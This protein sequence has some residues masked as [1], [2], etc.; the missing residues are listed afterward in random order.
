MRIIA[1][2]AKGTKLDT[3]SGYNTRPTSDRV[4]EAIFSAIHFDIEGANVLDI[5][6][7]SGQLGIEAISRGANSCVFVDMDKQSL[8]VIEKNIKR[9]GFERLSKVL[10]RDAIIYLSSISESFDIVLIDPP[11]G[12]KQQDEILIKL[13]ANLNT[14]GIVVYETAKDIDFSDSVGELAKHK[15]YV[16]GTTKVV[17]YK[18]I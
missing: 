17:I 5:F 13:S 15:E 2:S 16:Y 9:C 4:K 18:K 6:S 8:Q 14:G 1:G 3:P 7:G 10:N 12:Y 11:Y